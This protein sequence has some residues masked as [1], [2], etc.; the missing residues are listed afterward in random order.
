[1][2]GN[3][4]SKRRRVAVIAVRS[5]SQSL[6]RVAAR[7]VG[8]EQMALAWARLRGCMLHSRSR[9]VELDDADCPVWEDPSWGYDDGG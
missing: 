9:L 2:T 6:Q 1:M 7:V 8:H 4:S 5:E 3:V